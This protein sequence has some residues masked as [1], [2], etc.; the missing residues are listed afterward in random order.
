MSDSKLINLAAGGAIGVADLFYCD[1]GPGVDTKVTGLQLAALAPVQSVAG[2]TGAITL[3]AADVATALASANNAAPSISLYN[4]TDISTAN[5][6]GS[7][8]RLQLI[9]NR[10]GLISQTI[11]NTSNANFPSAVNA[12]GWIRAGG[13]GDQVFGLF[14]RAVAEVAGGASHELDAYNNSGQDAPLTVPRG[15]GF[16]TTSTWTTALTLA[17]GTTTNNSN[18]AGLYLVKDTSMGNGQFNYGIYY[19]PAAVKAVGL[20]LDADSANSPGTSIRVRNTG[21]GTNRHISTQTMGTAAP[22]TPVIEHL[23]ASAVATWTISQG[24]TFLGSALGIGPLAVA[25]DAPLTI[26]A[27]SAAAVAPPAGALVHLIGTDTIPAEITIDAYGSVGAILARTSGGAQGS[28]SAPAAN[29]QLFNLGAQGWD[30]VSA[31]GSAAGIV[32]FAENGFSTTDHSAYMDFK[33]CA[34]GS[35]TYQ[36]NMRLHGSGGLALGNSILA[37]DPGAGNHAVSG[38]YKVGANQVIGARVTGY[39]AMTG[40]PDKAST[41]ATSSVTLAQLAGR[42]MQMQADLTTHGLIGA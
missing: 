40:T 23:N 11:Q 30:G 2:R 15:D 9:Q 31:Y 8:Y 26:N 33:G 1:Q 29:A 6:F 35:T 18:W 38:A 21:Q 22:A 17:S 10:A 39:A 14:G 4:S 25:P 37:T 19:H 20:W 42:V 36:S 13:D 27:N 5:F 24:G 16:G 12:T 28:K 32:M 34:I 3:T 41:F 7:F